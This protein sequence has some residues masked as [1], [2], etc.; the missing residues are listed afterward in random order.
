MLVLGSAVA[1]VDNTVITACRANSAGDAVNHSLMGYY[2]LPNPFSALNWLF[3]HGFIVTV[4][5]HV[6]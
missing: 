5:V 3:F 6:A 4:V 2:V 1:L